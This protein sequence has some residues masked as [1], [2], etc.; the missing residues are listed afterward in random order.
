MKKKIIL[1]TGTPGVGKTTISRLLAKKLKALHINL[2]ELVKHENLTI[3]KDE[4]RG[5]LIADIDKLAERVRQIIERNEK[6]VIIDGHYATDVVLQGNVH[7]V[8]VLRRSPD[9]LKKTMETRGFKQEKIRENL[10]AE[11]LDVCLTDALATCGSEKVCEL[12][13]TDKKTAEV[14]KEVLQ[15]L[16]G[17]RQCQTGI[18]DW[19]G[20]LEAEGRLQEFLKEP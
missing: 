17:K 10:E 20:K 4:E 16:N 14:V 12:D 11:I 2:G 13:T 1:I 7:S 18:V 5:T 9:E 8:F 3:G 15:I 6:N 19:L